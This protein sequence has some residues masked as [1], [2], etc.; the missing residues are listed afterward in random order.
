MIVKN[1]IEG[2][3]NGVTLEL[4]S[5]IDISIIYGSN[6][7]RGI[8]NNYPSEVMIFDS[9][10]NGLASFVPENLW[11]LMEVTLTWVNGSDSKIGDL[12]PVSEFNRAYSRLSNDDIDHIKENYINWYAVAKRHFTVDNLMFSDKDVLFLVDEFSSMYIDHNGGFIL[13]GNAEHKEVWLFWGMV[14]SDDKMC[15]RVL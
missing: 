5:G 4:E 12:R 11:E 6:P 10:G 14:A 8:G 3:I 13:P 1:T 9:L 2:G 7:Y 15:E